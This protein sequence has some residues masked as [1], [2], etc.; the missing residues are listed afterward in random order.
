MKKKHKL[1]L[2]CTIF[3]ASIIVA[4]IFVYPSIATD[5]TTL[6]CDDCDANASA[7]AGRPVTIS[8]KLLFI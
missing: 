1:F 4:I 6:Q 8:K 3:F 2:T 5:R 7:I